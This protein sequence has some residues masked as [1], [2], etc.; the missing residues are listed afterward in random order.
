VR[1]AAGF[2]ETVRQ[3]G[4][5][6]HV[7]SCADEP[8]AGVACFEEIRTQWPEVTA[9]VTINEAALP[10]LQRALQFAGLEVPRDFSLTGVLADRLAEDFHPPLTAADVPAGEMARLAV[11]LL[12]EQVDGGVAEPRHV[13][14]EPP[15]SLRSSTGARPR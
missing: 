9:A 14:L 12:L 5:V 7:L 1:S 6:G 15:V 11:E 8:A 3:R 2:L 10:G 4:M 13:L